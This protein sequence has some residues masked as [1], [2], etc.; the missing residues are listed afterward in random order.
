MID[1]LGK[2]IRERLIGLVS[3]DLIDECL[4]YVV[5]E[6]GKTGGQGGCFDDRVIACAIAIQMYQ[7]R[8]DLVFPDIF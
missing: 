7:Q 8:H 4:T 1:D 6:D 5:L 3:K 2:A